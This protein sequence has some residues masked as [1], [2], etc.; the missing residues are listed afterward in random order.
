[1]GN[2][3]AQ[4]GALEACPIWVLLEGLSEPGGNPDDV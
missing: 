1:M 2:F 3:L 4:S